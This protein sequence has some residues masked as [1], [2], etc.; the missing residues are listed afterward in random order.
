MVLG[1]SG[2]GK[3]SLINR[4]LGKPIPD[5]H[6][7]TNALETDCKVEI[8][9]CDREWNECMED[10]S[11]LLDNYLTT[12]IENALKRKS[13]SEETQYTSDGGHTESKKQKIDNGATLINAKVT[14]DC[15]NAL[16]SA[17]SPKPSTSSEADESNIAFDEMEDPETRAEAKKRLSAIF[18]QSESAH[19]A[20]E[21]N[22]F[23]LSIWDLAGQVLYYV[24]H[25]IFL[26]S[27]C[28]YVLIVKLTKP[29]DST[30]PSHE[31]PPHTRQQSIKYHQEIEFWLNMIYSHMSKSKDG[32]QPQNILIV[33]THKD[34]LHDDVQQQ[35]LLAQAYFTE[36]QRLLIQKANFQAVHG[37]FIAVD[38]K[39]GD[40]QNFSRLRSLIFDVIEGHH[41]WKSPRPIRWLRLEKK[42][43]DLKYDDSL[44]HVDQHLVS[45][46]KVRELGKQ[47]H[48]ST[49]EDL[50]FFLEFHHLTGDFTYFS[51]GTMKHFVVPHPQ[52]LV[53]VFRALITL[54]QFSPQSRCL[55]E[56]DQLLSQ[57]LL[58]TDGLLL[59]EVWAKFLQGDAKGEAKQYLLDLMVGFDLAVKYDNDRYVIPS[60]LP[61]SPANTDPSSMVQGGVRNLP[62]IYFKFHSSADSHKDVLRGFEAYDNFL[63]HGLLQKLISKCSKRGWELSR[64]RRYQ[65]FIVFI[66]DDA[67]ISLR[68]RSTWIAL[69]V[70]PLNMQV[71]INYGKYLSEVDASLR[72][73]LGIYHKNMWFEICLKPCESHDCI[74]GVGKSSFD[75]LADK[76]K[77][78]G[79]TC[80]SHWRSIATPEF[81]MWFRLN[82]CRVL[83][84]KDLRK[85]AHELTDIWS[86]ECLAAELDVPVDYSMVI[87][88]T[89]K[90]RMAT[91]N[92][93]SCWFNQRTYKVHA[94]VAFCDSLKNVGL[95]RL[96]SECLV[97]DT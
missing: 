56:K 9:H 88:N 81:D 46:D 41:N 68:A 24:L 30:V 11:E 38:S 13:E 55:Q 93:L 61:V 91:F 63:P 66:V 73:L 76:S 31:L 82:P 65:D 20:K 35:E 8:T 36:L 17:P 87:G 86:A 89:D 40:P 58:K 29:L 54:E 15:Q 4:L 62:E 95:E 6:I 44:P 78:H 47:F 3:T 69:N 22:K 67:L 27:Q 43:H 75:E 84:P 14:D 51:R 50:K 19:D 71:S 42:L 1:A 12:G 39:N 7:V 90:I 59:G 37:T 18:R 28:I 85:I 10:H 32:Q 97:H 2:D 70:F 21:K 26:R 80:P 83:R 60:L 64:D 96:I 92:M 45:F 72:S 25:H 94:F 53:D 49:E 34:K 23:L 52:W 16:Q 77:L 48:I 79:V 33:G 57:G 74:L 5:E